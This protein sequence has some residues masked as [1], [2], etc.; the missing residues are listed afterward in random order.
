MPPWPRLCGQAPCA[1]AAL[2]VSWGAVTD[3]PG[4]GHRARR[5]AAAAPRTR[6]CPPERRPRGTSAPCR[7]VAAGAERQRSG[8]Q[9][10]GGQPGEADGGRGGRSGLRHSLER[11]Y[12]PP[13]LSCGLSSPARLC[14]RRGR[15]PIARLFPQPAEPTRPEEKEARTQI[16]RCGESRWFGGSA[17]RQGCPEAGQK[18]GGRRG[19]QRRRWGT[20]LPRAG[21]GGSA[22]GHAAAPALPGGCGAVKLE[23]AG[24][25]LHQLD[26]VRGAA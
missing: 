10:V 13:S 19:R 17:S 4:T 9:G 18:R 11:L 8:G 2:A 15:V 14:H 26:G 24:R 5:G 23:L 22:I 3:A 12:L 21:S 1:T 20:R 25:S 6:P 7:A 16:P